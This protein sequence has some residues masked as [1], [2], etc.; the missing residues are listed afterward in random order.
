MGERR[1][2]SAEE[3]KLGRCVA[4]RRSAPGKSKILSAEGMCDQQRA[5]CESGKSSMEDVEMYRS[6]KR[7][8]SDG[9]IV[10]RQPDVHEFE[11]KRYLKK[12]KEQD[13]YEQYA[14]LQGMAIRMSEMRSRVT[15]LNRRAFPVKGSCLLAV[16]TSK[17]VQ[18][19]MTPVWELSGKRRSLFT[20]TTSLI[21]RDKE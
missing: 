2:S 5:G 19:S 9:L 3:Q 13:M 17:R 10:L 16:C 20:L 4:K 1:E 12:V 11:T 15:P 14:G 21:A 6:I 7:L 18:D 8:S